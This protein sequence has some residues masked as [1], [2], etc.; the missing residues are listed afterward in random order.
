MR[1]TCAFSYFYSLYGNIFSADTLSMSG[2]K[3]YSFL[4]LELRCFRL[5]TLS[6]LNVLRDNGPFM[7][8]EVLHLRCLLYLVHKLR[9]KVSYQSDPVITCLT[10]CHYYARHFGI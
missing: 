2:H 9:L 10:Y 6:R 4:L 5:L 8:R 7:K 3:N 1:P